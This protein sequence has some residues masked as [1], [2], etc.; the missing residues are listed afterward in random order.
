MY[1]FLLVLHM[2]LIIFMFR[3]YIGED[4]GDREL[5]LKDC[6]NCFDLRVALAGISCR[7]PKGTLA[8]FS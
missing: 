6:N 7:L 4:V 5:L 2:L 1:T 3:V 8:I